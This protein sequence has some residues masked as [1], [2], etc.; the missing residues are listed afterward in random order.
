MQK[1]TKLGWIGLGVMGEPMCSHL[2]AAGYPVSVYT[3]S[4]EKAQ[5]VINAGANWCDTPAAITKECDVIFTMVGSEQEVR[6]VYFSDSGL[7][8][9]TINDKIFIDMGTTAPSL[10]RELAQ[11]AA[12]QG[13]HIIDA[14]VSG[15]DVGAQNASLSIM[16]GGDE[17][18]VNKVSELFSYLGRVQAMG[19]SG[20]GQHTKMCNQ[21]VVA[22]TMIGV[23]ESLL[24]AKRAGLD[25]ETLIAA[26]RPGAAGCWTLDNLAPRMVQQDFSSGF[27]V[28]HFIKDLAIAVSEAETMKLD[29]PGLLLASSLYK[30]VRE[31]GYGR[32]AT[33]ALLL[34]L[35]HET[36]S[37]E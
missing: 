27:M 29:L 8:S 14:P 6:D 34:A 4:K 30:K 37:S 9:S 16:A 32:S 25:C 12:Q 7:F 19:K 13:A 33:Q 22:G 26:I 35:D 3:R 28:D 18:I 1:N 31:M 10:T 17:L 24:Y 21:I 5:S 15:G 36:R 2:L 23:C 20:N 11:Y